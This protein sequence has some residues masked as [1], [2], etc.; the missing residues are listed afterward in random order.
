MKNML[1]LRLGPFVGQVMNN[2]ACLRLI[3]TIIVFAVYT[4]FSSNHLS[5]QYEKD[6]YTFIHKIRPPKTRKHS[7]NELMLDPH[8]R[9]LILTVSSN[10]THILFYG[11]TNWELYKEYMV[12]GWFDLG[13]SF[14]DPDGRYLFIDFGRYSSKYR[15]IDLTTDK[16][17][18]VECN[19]TPRGCIPKEPTLPKKELYT[20]NKTFY[21]NIN[22]NSRDVLIFKKND[23]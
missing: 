5:A 10:P 6:G 1:Y 13:N 20:N 22:S 14:V 12:A 15:R 11:M 23:E 16:I 19:M 3:P 4:I 18:T 7:V 8:G 2:T 21:I 17:D 9:F